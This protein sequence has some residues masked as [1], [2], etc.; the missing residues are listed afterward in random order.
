[1][2]KFM[3]GA[4]LLGIVSAANAGS[5]ADK[6]IEL[7]NQGCIVQWN[8]S[9]ASQSCDAI[10][11]NIGESNCGIAAQCIA[12]NGGFIDNGTGYYP[13]SQ[14]PQIVNCNGRLRTERC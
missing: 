3:L 5:G 9:R 11:W 10:V 14:V 8:L 12:D 7:T 6:S 4:L 13:Y 1:M 2:K